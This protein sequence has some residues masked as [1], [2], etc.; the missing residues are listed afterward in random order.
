[1][2]HHL[3]NDSSAS[4]GPVTAAPHAL[5]RRRFVRG[6]FAAPAVMTVCSGSAYGADPLTSAT[7]LVK[8]QTGLD[9]M[10][11]PFWT[12]TETPTYLRVTVYEQGGIRYVRYGDLGA[13]GAKG[14]TSPVPSAG[15]NDFLELDANGALTGN[16]LPT[17]ANTGAPSATSSAVV[18]RIDG[19][20]F[21]VGTGRGSGTQ[22]A[23][24]SMTCWM[25]VSPFA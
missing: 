24:V 16:V 9:P 4:A 20:G 21:V 19:G 18:V 6:V 1:M 12:G 14:V 22:G 2:S 8:G 5:A 7:C 17:H 23:L 10:V 3:P 15:V 13:I 25:S 11:D